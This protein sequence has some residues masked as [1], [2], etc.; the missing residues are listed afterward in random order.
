VALAQLIR[1]L[2]VKL[3]YICLNF[4]FDMG[5]TFMTNYFLVGGNVLID[6]NTLLVTD[7]VNLNRSS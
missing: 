7:F 6:S 1:F 2:V 3:I 4:K 5:V